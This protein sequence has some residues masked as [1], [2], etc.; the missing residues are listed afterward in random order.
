MEAR[1]HLTGLW[2]RACSIED[3]IEVERL[4]SVSIPNFNGFFF[5]PLVK[6]EFLHHAE[7]IHL[8]IVRKM[9]LI[10]IWLKPFAGK[11]VAFITEFY[12]LLPNALKY[13]ALPVRLEQ[14]DPAFSGFA[15]FAGRLLLGN[16]QAL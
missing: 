9:G 12:S 13:L 2:A 7:L 3:V 1:K 11:I 8:G 6:S 15:S 16:T 14:P 4:G 10:R 5:G